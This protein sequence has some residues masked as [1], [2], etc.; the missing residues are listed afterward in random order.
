[1]LQVSGT[2]CLGDSTN[3]GAY[4]GK[5]KV[6]VGKFVAN[7]AQTMSSDTVPRSTAMRRRLRWSTK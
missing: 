5:Y 1:M 6:L 3:D 2:V 7:K 4:P